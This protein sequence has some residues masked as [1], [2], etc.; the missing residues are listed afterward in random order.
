[1][2][3]MDVN[4]NRKRPSREDEEGDQLLLNTKTPKQVFNPLDYVTFNSTYEISSQWKLEH[5][6]DRIHYF[7]SA[8]ESFLNLENTNFLRQVSAKI[9]KNQK[10]PHCTQYDFGERRGTHNKEVTLL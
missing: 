5:H 1:M 9:S 2:S 6:Q 8:Q 7:L 4:A 3:S 10:V